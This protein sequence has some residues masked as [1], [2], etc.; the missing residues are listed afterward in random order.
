M[1]CNPDNLNGPAQHQYEIMLR[2]LDD[3]YL[4]IKRRK[5]TDENSEKV[6]MPLSI[7]PL[8]SIYLLKN[9]NQII[10]CLDV[11][12]C[13]LTDTPKNLKLP[14]LK[15]LNLSH[16][17]FTTI[18]E[19]FYN[20]LNHLEYLDLSFNLIS[21]FDATPNCVAKLQSLNLDNNKFVN[22]PSWFLNFVCRNLAKLSYCDNKSTN[23]KFLD[24]CCNFFTMKLEKLEL[25]NACLIDT[26]FKWIK[27]IKNLNYLDI[28]NKSLDCDRKYKNKFK[29]VDKLF[30]KTRCR[31]LQ[32]LKMNFLDLVL[33]PE[34]LFWI[35]SLK[36][37]HITNNFLSWFPE[38]G[39]EYLV[40]LEFL[41][42][43]CNDLVALPE[44]INELTNLKTIIAYKN[45]IEF[46]T[47]LPNSLE[48]L[49]LYDNN[50]EDFEND[51]VN[52]I[53][54]VDFD[55]NHVD[56][57]EKDFDYKLYSEK[58]RDLRLQFHYQNRGEDGIKIVEIHPDRESKLSDREEESEEI[59]KEMAECDKGYD[60]E[61]ATWVG[62]ESWD[63][64]DKEVK[65]NVYVD[66]EEYLYVDAD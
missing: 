49:D 7:N 19:F 64:V 27:L 54:L 35:E 10:T 45:R 17:K 59:A 28:S 25:R 65:Y 6:L 61:D 58:R 57:L 13:A 31:N 66:L 30:Q 26:D 60:S 42:V 15:H 29:D 36:E 2:I 46:I 8:E 32:V 24:H 52:D 18:P 50:L 21:S 12:Y 5:Q 40:N 33:C 38:E 34:G 56:V 4:A 39:I 16:N 9:T 1:T 3:K 53:Y 43:S 14:H 44:K 47:S 37:L 51:L 41:D 20:G 23:F 55:Y 48:C 63:S 11:S 62:E 22:V